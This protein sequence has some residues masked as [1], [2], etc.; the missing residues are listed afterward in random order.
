MCLQLKRLANWLAET[1]KNTQQDKTPTH[2]GCM[3]IHRSATCNN[4]N[5]SNSHNKA[6]GDGAVIVPLSEFTQFIY[7]RRYTVIIA[8]S[9]ATKY[10]TDNAFIT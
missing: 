1:A 7:Q 4:S 3:N 10:K 8:I 5:T 2:L 9:T 6:Y